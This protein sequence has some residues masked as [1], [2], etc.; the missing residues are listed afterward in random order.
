ME[1]H[2]REELLSKIILLETELSNTN[3]RIKKYKKEIKNIENS[4][5][6]KYSS[7][8]RKLSN[9]A[10]NHKISELAQNIH[11]LEEQVKN[12]EDEI[13]FVRSIVNASY[14][15]MKKLLDGNKGD[16]LN[17]IDQ[18][19]RQKEKS[20]EYYRKLTKHIASSYKKERAEVRNTVYEKLLAILPVE[21]VPEMITRAGF[22]EDPLALEG[23]S[24]FRSSLNIRQRE[25]QLTGTLPEWVLD[26]KRMAYAFVDALDIRRPWYSENVYSVSQIPEKENVVIKPVDGAGS[27]GVY[28]IY[29]N[30]K[31]VDIKR[32]L[33][34]NSWEELQGKMQQDLD[35]GAVYQDEWFMEELVF[36][37]KKEKTPASDVKFYCFYG[38]V[39]LV[40]E[41]TR[42]PDLMY[43][44]WT[45]EGKRIRTG[46][47]D[48][49]LF[50]GK[51]FSQEEIQYVSEISKQ[52]PAPF[53]RIDFLRSE[54][55][56]VF[57]E[58]TPKPGNYDEF[59][60]ETDR[61]LGEY[62]LEANGRLTN[63]LINGKRFEAY[64]KVFRD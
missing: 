36:E 44:W 53:I 46:K 62:Y 50:Q 7:P 1:N 27:R 14:A 64:Q 12:N 42:Y 51:G 40:L 41:I 6:W 38:K 57:G 48:E 25:A 32:N 33:P 61:R 16:T 49:L 23:L 58:F 15:D 21:D 31:I 55:E 10:E 47:Y 39:G 56:L 26:N 43:C 30:K 52:I 54:N 45:P 28:L 37:N 3:K 29:D 5:T 4:K 22:G 60:K 9:R 11:K 63:D 18:L 13:T 24:S 17:Y 2:Q 8:L 19:A 59:N 20:D 35:S 34:L